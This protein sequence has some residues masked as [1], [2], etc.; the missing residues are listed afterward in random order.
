MDRA[1][2]VVS[3]VT[4]L[5]VSNNV[6][7]HHNGVHTNEQLLL[8]YPSRLVLLVYYVTTLF[9]CMAGVAV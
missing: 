2:G 5:I 7:I 3:G 8:A 4:R 9:L 1:L 6:F